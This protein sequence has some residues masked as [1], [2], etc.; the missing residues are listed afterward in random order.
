VKPSAIGDQRGEHPYI[1]GSRWRARHPY[2]MLVSDFH[3]VI[4]HRNQAGMRRGF[5]SLPDCCWPSSVAGSMRI[6]GCHIVRERP[7]F[8]APESVW[9]A[10]GGGGHRVATPHESPRARSACL[11]A[12]P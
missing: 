5:R 3:A 6:W 7:F 8:R 10:A 11:H 12:G 4:G 1:S 2:P 9:K